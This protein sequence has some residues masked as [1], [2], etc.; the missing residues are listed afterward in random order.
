MIVHCGDRRLSSY[1]YGWALQRRHVRTTKGGKEKVE[2]LEESYPASL[3]HGLQMILEIELRNAGD[4]DVSEL[5]RRLKQAYEAV[6][7]YTQ[8]ARS[9]A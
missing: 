1:K 3:G 2:W 6:K 5:P 9:A 4:C 7:E 8:K